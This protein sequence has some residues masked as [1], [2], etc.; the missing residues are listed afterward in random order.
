MHPHGGAPGNELILVRHGQSTANASGIWQGQLDYPLSPLGREQAAE[1][2]RSLAGIAI[3]A[4]YTS[5]LSRASETARILAREAGY[6]GPVVE[7][8]GLQERHGG[9]LQG[10][11]WAEQEAENPAFAR[12]FLSIPEEERWTLVGAETDK[13][14]IA[15]FREAVGSILGRHTAGGET[16]VAVSH[17]G[18]M[19]AYLR[20]LFGGGVLPGKER[21]P[22]ASVTRLFFPARSAEGEPRL[23]ALPS[24][25]PR[26]PE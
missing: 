21:L 17:G 2:G 15:R 3:A 9:V 12:K 10:K 23:L 7:V 24:A 18:V 6:G 13:E 25:A 20:D 22:N 5:P 14:I 16:V 4:V 11:T 19:R 26:R 1:A 8:E